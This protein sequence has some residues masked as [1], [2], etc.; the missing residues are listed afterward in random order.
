M[1]EKKRIVHWNHNDFIFWKIKTHFLFCYRRIHDFRRK[2]MWKCCTF[3]FM[4]HFP[5]CV[6]LYISHSL[7]FIWISHRKHVLTQQ[8]CSHARNLTQVLIEHNNTWWWKRILYK[9]CIRDGASKIDEFSGAKQFTFL[10]HFICE[11]V[12]ECVCLLPLV[13]I[14]FAICV[15]KTCI[16]LLVTIHSDDHRSFYL[17]IWCLSETRFSME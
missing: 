6:T 9:T 16:P 10:H 5:F 4:W 3:D 11:W 13:H 1:L 17:E 8:E 15:Y 12:N 14:P 7:N 2:R